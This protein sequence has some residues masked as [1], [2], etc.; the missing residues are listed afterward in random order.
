MS[1]QY[2]AIF[3]DCKNDIFL[4]E[5]VIFFSFFFFGAKNI[6]LGYTLELSHYGCF[7]E[8]GGSNEYS[9]SMF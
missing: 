8:W 3:H 5:N 6:D 2:T 9:K 1:M 4:M 7:N